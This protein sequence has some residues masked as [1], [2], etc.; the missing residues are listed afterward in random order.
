[1]WQM[2]GVL[3]EL[4]RSLIVERTRAGVKAAQKRG[5]RF[6]HKPKLTPDRLSHAR[7]LIDHGNA[8][9]EAA[10]IMAVSRATLYRALQREAA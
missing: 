10:K 6:G 1:M 7:K 3:A 8:P 4:E 2:I 5:V 9:T